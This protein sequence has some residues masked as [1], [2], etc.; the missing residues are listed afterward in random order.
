MPG[1]R[2]EIF[3]GV[4]HFPQVEEPVR[5]VEVVEDFL[6]TTEAAAPVRAAS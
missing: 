6:A 3:D 4:G 2:L 5:F 1:S